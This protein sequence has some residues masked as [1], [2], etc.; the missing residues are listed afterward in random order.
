MR[1]PCCGCALRTV[2]FGGCRCQAY[3]LTGDASRTDPACHRSPD[4]ATVR[5]LV[6][7]AGGRASDFVYRA[8][9]Q[10]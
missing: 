6:G 5:A 10:T 7:G 8:S 4:N 2:D 1:E 9:P 3:A